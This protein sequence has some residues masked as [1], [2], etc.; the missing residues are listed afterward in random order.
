M[1]IANRDMGGATTAAADLAGKGLDA[2]VVGADLAEDASINHA[3]RDGVDRFVLPWILVSNA[4]NQDHQP[5]WKA[6]R[7][8]G[9]G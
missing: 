7:W 4:G 6:P 5:L 8:N 3:C 2:G 9:T 1:V